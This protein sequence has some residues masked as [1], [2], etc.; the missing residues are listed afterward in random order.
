MSVEQY[1]SYIQDEN[2]LNNIQKL[3]VYRNEEGM[4]QPGQQILTATDKI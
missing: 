2:K 3:H 4:V 1:F